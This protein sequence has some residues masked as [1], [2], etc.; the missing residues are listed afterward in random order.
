MTSNYDQLVSQLDELVGER[1]AEIVERGS[2]LKAHSNM[3]TSEKS[4]DTTVQKAMC[5]LASLQKS[6]TAMTQRQ[7]KK[8]VEQVPAIMMKAQKAFLSGQITGDQLCMI[9][10]KKNRLCSMMAAKGLIP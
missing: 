8:S 5:T 10:A 6:A 1:N 7:N 3:V 4:L 9:E 2:I